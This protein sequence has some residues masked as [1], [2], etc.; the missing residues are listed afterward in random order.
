M[1]NLMQS[2]VLLWSIRGGGIG[3]G[4]VPV[5]LMVTDPWHWHPWLIRGINGT[6]GIAQP[7]PGSAAG[8]GYVFGR[9]CILKC[10][11][12]IQWLL[13]WAGKADGTADIAKSLTSPWPQRGAGNGLLSLLCCRTAP[14]ELAETEREMETLGLASQPHL[15]A[16]REAALK[17]YT[18]KHSTNMPHCRQTLCMASCLR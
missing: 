15:A 3:A 13:H 18:W 16:C 4:D 6:N 17:C 9:D 7:L 11:R 5:Q 8:N 12:P 2:P 14:G 10:W 1:N